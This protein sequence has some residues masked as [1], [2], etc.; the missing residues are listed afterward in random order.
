MK[1]ILLTSIFVFAITAL[2]AQA[3]FT[4]ADMPNIGDHDTVNYLNYQTITNNL[5]AETGNGYNWNFTTLP[6]S[7]YPNFYTVDSFRVKTHTVSQPFTNA[8]IEEYVYDGTA[9][10]VNLFSYSND[11]L[12]F[13]RLGSVLNGSAYIPPIAYI[14][15]PIQF[16]HTSVIKSNFYQ[17]SVILGMRTT[18]TLYDG[19]GTLQMPNNKTFTNVFRIKKIEKDTSY[20]TNTSN[21][22]ISYIWYKQGG[23]IPLL[24][25]AF[26]GSTNLYFVFG[27]RA[28]NTSTVIIEN[29]NPM[30]FSIYPNPS[31][32][33]F[34]ISELNSVPDNIEVYNI[35]GEKIIQLHKS[36]EINLTDFPKG[37][38][39]V[40]IFQGN[41]SVTK[42]IIL[43]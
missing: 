6:F 10:D 38:Y 14:A 28:K 19:F 3:N 15:F 29:N 9:G 5:D 25:L 17:G 8:S 16:N 35:V 2:F 32:G 26:S 1:K 34:S 21:T 43:Q 39:F 13:H 37:C 7:T 22:A 24:R 18:T 27:S 11:T 12:Y 41:T 36:I 23:Q 4:S 20:L 33:I 31:N 42:R 40:K 30:N